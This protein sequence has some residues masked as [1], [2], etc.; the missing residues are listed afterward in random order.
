[1]SLEQLC[2]KYNLNR[3]VLTFELRRLKGQGVSE[4][5]F[6]IYQQLKAEGVTKFS[7][8]EFSVKL[9][10][11]DAIFYEDCFFLTLKDVCREYGT[12]TSLVKQ[13]YS[14]GTSLT[15]AID[16]AR[17]KTKQ[18]TQTKVQP[19]TTKE[20]L[21]FLN[22]QPKVR[23]IIEKYNLNARAL[24]Y[25]A[26]KS[27]K[28][29]DKY[30]V[31]VEKKI[32]E[33]R[34]QNNIGITDTKT[35][36]SHSV[37]HAS[38]SRKSN[39]KLTIKSLGGQ[40]SPYNAHTL[41]NDAA[42]LRLPLQEFI[43]KLQQYNILPLYL[44]DNKQPTFT[45]RGEIYPNFDSFVH[46]N[47]LQIIDVRL[48]TFQSEGDIDKALALAFTK[49]G[50]TKGRGKPVFYN[51]KWYDSMRHLSNTFNI[52]YDTLV[53]GLKICYL[54]NSPKTV[55]E[56][57]NELIFNSKNNY[58]T[59]GEK[60]ILLKTP[61]NSYRNVMHLC[62]VENISQHHLSRAL[63]QGYSLEQSIQYAKNQTK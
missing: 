61:T 49:R 41:S 43:T 24:I 58:I 53:K 48:F 30:I 37:E 23:A 7:S 26:S 3:S 44:K 51:N 17:Q 62:K 60:R 55:D 42:A 52:P 12:Q 35:S 36:T 59:V 5:Q 4:E 38:R 63:K 15:S 10:P 14:R 8:K 39:N 54:P 11:N 6:L 31:L 46:S 20:E 28:S 56:V 32:I 33:A 45:Y 9:A 22:L 25:E 47:D 13:F 40:N 50:T 19:E 1:M 2:G 16:K 29:L 57:V 21:D 18:P 34:K 27:G